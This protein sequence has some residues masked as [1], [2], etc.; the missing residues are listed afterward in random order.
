MQE[1][2]GADYT[3]LNGSAHLPS[4][5]DPAMDFSRHTFPGSS[6]IPAEQLV[7]SRAS[8]PIVISTARTGLLP[9][10]FS[11]VSA[12]A[13]VMR[14]IAAAGLCHLNTCAFVIR[15]FKTK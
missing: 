11:C 3:N 14:S 2:S 6:P 13:P 9:K 5:I 15:G 7:A 10:K 12:V 4:S 8:A 1:A